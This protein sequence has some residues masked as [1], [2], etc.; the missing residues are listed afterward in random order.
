MGEFATEF[1][2]GTRLDATGI[3]ES[4]LLW[5]VASVIPELF[6]Q[7]GFRP[8]RMCDVW[9][10]EKN[11]GRQ[12]GKAFVKGGGAATVNALINSWQRVSNSGS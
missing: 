4:A 10:P 2:G 6:R 3:G 8:Y 9:N 12:Y 11:A 1:V 5:A 7:V